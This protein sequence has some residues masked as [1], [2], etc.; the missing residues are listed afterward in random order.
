MPDAN[1]TRIMITPTTQIVEL[2]AEYDDLLDALEAIRLQ[3]QSESCHNQITQTKLRV[4]MHR[5]CEAL[6]D[7]H[8]RISD[9]VMM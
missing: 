8:E 9:F 7:V 3:L 6:A 5:I 2:Y 4:Q 1:A